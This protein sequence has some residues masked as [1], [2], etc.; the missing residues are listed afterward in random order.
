MV[1]STSSEPE[2][3]APRTAAMVTSS[4]VLFPVIDTPAPFKRV[5]V[6][7]VESATGLVPDGALMVA[8]VFVPEP[9]LS[10][11]QVHAAPSH[12]ITSWLPQ[13]LS[14]RSAKRM[15]P[16][17]ISEESIELP[18]SFAKFSV[19]VPPRLTAPPPVK[20]VPAVTVRLLFARSALATDPSVISLP[21]TAS[22]NVV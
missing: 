22:P 16:L 14:F 10:A 20:P 13:P 12:L 6:S 11:A 21:S 15:V 5:K 18:K 17:V 1:P 7:L 19:T 2:T 9:V 4:V 3:S 8:K